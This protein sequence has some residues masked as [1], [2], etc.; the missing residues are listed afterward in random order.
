MKYRSET[1]FGDGYRDAAPVMAHETFELMNT[2]I[3]RTLRD[4]ILK[5]S[6][7]AEKLEILE[8]EIQNGCIAD[9]DD[10]EL[11]NLIETHDSYDDD[12][13]E[14][15]QF[16]RDILAEIKTITGKDI[17]YVLWLCDTKEDV[18]K[19]DLHNELTDD[20]IDAYEESDIILS[21][22][23]SEGKLYGFETNPKPIS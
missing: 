3:I 20:D 11:Y 12:S 14:S 1:L 21:D 16:F 15:I 18:K 7:F 19:Y 10:G 13:C 8:E 9:G 6:S 17:K 2:D 5:D 23:G 4:T 22:L